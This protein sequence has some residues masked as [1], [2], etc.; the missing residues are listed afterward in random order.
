MHATATLPRAEGLRTSSRIAVETSRRLLFFAVAGASF[1][2]LFLAMDLRIGVY[3]EG[4][5]LTAAMRELAG[6]IPHRDFY[7]AYGP[8]QSYLLALLFRLFEP[9]VLAARLLDLFFKSLVIASF[10][11]ILARLVRPRLAATATALLFLLVFGLSMPGSA[12]VPVC[13]AALWA[14][15][16]LVPA[17]AARL[18]LREAFAAGLLAGFAA[19]FRYDLGVA[20]AAALLLILLSAATLTRARPRQFVPAAGVGLLGFLALALPAAAAYLSRAP[21]ADFRFDV[22]DYPAHLFRAGRNLP[23][24][25]P[26]LKTLD[27]LA[28]YVPFAAILLAG[29][30]LLPHPASAGPRR[31][32]ELPTPR[33][34]ALLAFTL[35]AVPFTLKGTVR[36]SPVQMFPALVPALLILAV[37]LELRAGLAPAL[38]RGLALAVAALCLSTLWLD[39]HRLKDLHSAHSSAFHA[40]L[41][42]SPPSN[43]GPLQVGLA[44]DPGNSHRQAI[45]FV[46]ANTQ[47]RD[48]L[49][50]GVT[51]HDRIFANDNLTYFAAGRLPATKWSEFDPGLQNQAVIQQQM[52][53]DLER[54]PPPYLL[55]DAEFDEVREPNASSV[56]SG[57]LLLDRYLAAHYVRVRTWDEVS[58]WQRK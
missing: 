31:L 36:V 39:L 57:V 32:R 13:L 33:M 49:Y 27:D 19:L 28:I 14:T 2:A 18:R 22:F 51:H 46:V 34:A 26:H 24:P 53:A 1:A 3:D 5:V 35:V 45:D 25:I 41:Y 52:I 23:F 50:V 38:R 4:L 42:P 44:F 6:Q 9:S 11:A 37:L 47:P 55:L 10:H 12:A 15:W 8:A 48:P 20:L 7:F 54:N 56:S 43:R 29:S 40:L 16:L 17:F 58:A 30:A 21:F